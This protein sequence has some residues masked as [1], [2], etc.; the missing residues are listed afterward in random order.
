MLESSAVRWRFKRNLPYVP[1]PVLYDGVFYMVKSGGIITA[2][3]PAN[4]N[5]LKQGR[6]EK[7]PGEYFASPVASGGKVFLLSAEGKVTVLKASREWEVLAV[8]DLGDE[9][10]A[11]PAITGGRIFVRTRGTL[12]AFAE[13]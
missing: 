10:Y 8:N 1:A 2:L 5:L 4:G 6:S 11:S 7:A 13:R 12:F 9:A 3:D